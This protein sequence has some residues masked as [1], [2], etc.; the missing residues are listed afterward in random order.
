MHVMFVASEATPYSKTGGL[1]D[2]C[3]A[4]PKALS[5]LGCKVSIV[6]PLYKCAR[7]YF[8]HSNERLESMYGVTLEAVVGR[9]TKRAGV[10][11][12]KL[13]GSEVDVYFIEHD[14]YFNR[15]GIYNNQGVD[16]SDNCERYSFFSRSALELIR[17]L[18]LDV[19]VINANDWQTGLVPVYLDSIYKT[20]SRFEYDSI[21]GG[22]G[23]PRYDAS[24]RQGANP[25]DRIK[26]VITIHNL[27]HQGRFWLDGSDGARL[28]SLYVR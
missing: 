27:R 13:T 18:N 15:D 4:L 12:T 5:Q 28:E 10:Q 24:V 2:V 14:D 16:Y 19:D 22:A 7:E 6:T 21:F 3:S 8:T 26:T 20:R 11:R 23:R 25:F 9:E 1:A 17:V